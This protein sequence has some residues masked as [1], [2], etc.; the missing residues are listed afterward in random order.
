[1]QNCLTEIKL[2]KPSLIAVCISNVKLEITIELWETGAAGTLNSLWLTRCKYGRTAAPLDL[3]V[4]HNKGV[5]CK[6]I[7]YHPVW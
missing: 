7:G 6:T 1:V 4:Q 2:L 5:V 3:V